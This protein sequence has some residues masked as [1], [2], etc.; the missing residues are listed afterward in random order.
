MP[1]AFPYGYVPFGQMAPLQLPGN[2]YGTEVFQLNTNL[3]AKVLELTADTVLIDSDA[4]KVYRKC[5][6]QHPTRAV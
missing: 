2:Y 6:A 3:L 1:K 4:M 5:P